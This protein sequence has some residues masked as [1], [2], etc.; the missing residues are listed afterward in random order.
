[1]TVDVE[2]LAEEVRKI[3]GRPTIGQLARGFLRTAADGLV[4]LEAENKRLRKERDLFKK[5][6]VDAEGYFR[7]YCQNNGI[8]EDSHYFEARILRQIRSAFAGRGCEE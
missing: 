5:V 4:Q 6:A 3:A 7:E 2:S 1:M 8:A